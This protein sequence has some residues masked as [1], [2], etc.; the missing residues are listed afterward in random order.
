MDKEVVVVDFNVLLIL[1]DEDG[2]RQENRLQLG[3]ITM[4]LKD[5]V[6]VNVRIYNAYHSENH[7]VYESKAALLRSGTINV[8]VEIPVKARGPLNVST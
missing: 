3:P 8:T 1:I 7:T 2:N 5:V 4:D 6:A